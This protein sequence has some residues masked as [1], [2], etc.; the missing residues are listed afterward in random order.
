VVKLVSYVVNDVPDR[1]RGVSSA[2]LKFRCQFEMMMNSSEN[3]AAFFCTWK[4]GSRAS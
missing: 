3:S 2:S 4:R 1:V